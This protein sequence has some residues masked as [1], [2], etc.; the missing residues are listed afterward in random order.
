MSSRIRPMISFAVVLL[1]GGVSMC[2]GGGT[3]PC[4]SALS[5]LLHYSD[6]GEPRVRTGYSLTLPPPPRH[7]GHGETALGTRDIDR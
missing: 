1:I 6:N 7:M 4:K 2:E 3:E 5:R